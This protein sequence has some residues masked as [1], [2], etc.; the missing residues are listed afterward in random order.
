M[1]KPSRIRTV[2]LGCFQSPPQRWVHPVSCRCRRAGPAL[3][4]RCHWFQTSLGKHQRMKTPEWW[5]QSANVLSL[6][7]NIA[8]LNSMISW[9]GHNYIPFIVHRYTIWSGELSILC[10]LAA[11]ELNHIRLLKSLKNFQKVYTWALQKFS[12]ITSS[13]WLLKSVT[14]AW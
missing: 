9:I 5:R 12:L 4:G 6:V 8:N 14:I 11:Q 1:Y 13:R 10:S 7:S 3:Q 2:R